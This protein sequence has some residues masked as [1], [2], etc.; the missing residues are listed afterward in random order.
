MPSGQGT[1]CKKDEDIYYGWCTKETSKDSPLYAALCDVSDPSFGSKTVELDPDTGEPQILSEDGDAISSSS[2]SSF[3]EVLGPEQRMWLRDSLLQSTASLKIIV[4]PSVLITNPVPST[5]PGPPTNM[6]C[7]C[8]GDDFG[9]YRPAQRQ[10]L[11]LLS[12]VPGCLVVLVGDYHF[13]D[14]KVIR[15]GADQQYAET[16]G[17]ADNTVPIYQVMASG[18]TTRTAVSDLPCQGYRRDPMRLRDGHDECAFVSQTNFGFIEVEWSR[19]DDDIKTV[20]LQ[21][22][23]GQNEVMLQSI[24]TPDMC[25]PRTPSVAG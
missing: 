4:S 22:R 15:P 13:A 17:S 8:G 14:I 23:N 24:I 20:G 21:V 6:T 16:F 7:H 5:C 18:L 11:S 19:S 25:N 10:L 1:C 9:C 12:Q 2:S 3:C